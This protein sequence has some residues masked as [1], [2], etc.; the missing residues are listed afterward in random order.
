MGSGL[1]ICIGK[2]P[3]GE[4]FVLSLGAGLL[5]EGS[6]SRISMAH[7]SQHEKRK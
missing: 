7:M 6:M 2:V 4:L 3:L 1:L 5:E